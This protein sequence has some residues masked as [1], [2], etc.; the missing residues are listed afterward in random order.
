MIQLLHETECYIRELISPMA[1]DPFPITPQMQTSPKPSLDRTLVAERDLDLLRRIVLR[2]EAAI[3]ELYDR[4]SLLVYSVANH[5]LAD[6]GLAEDVLQ[7]IFLQLWR[8]PETFD[9]TRGSLS[10]WLTVMA[11]HRAIDRYRRRRPEI[12]VSELIIPI[13][14]TQFGDVHRIESALQLRRLLEQMP[15]VLREAVE[16]AYFEGLTHSQIG[17]QLGAPLGTIKSR[18]RLGLE[19]LRARFPDRAVGLNCDKSL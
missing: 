12:D 10:T 3:R 7:E 15:M 8:A 11:R 14:G 19:W 4:Y 2:E 5:V 13:S 17:A 18:I 1:A 16:L 9:A 6:D